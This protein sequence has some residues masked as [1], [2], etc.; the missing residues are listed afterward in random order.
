[1]ESVEQKTKNQFSFCIQNAF[2]DANSRLSLDLGLWTLVSNPAT[3]GFSSLRLGKVCKHPLLSLRCVGS[4]LVSRL[5][6]LI[7]RIVLNLVD[8]LLDVLLVGTRA[9]EQHILGVYH[10]IVAQTV[11]DGYLTLRK[12]Y[13]R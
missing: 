5:N 10:D 3:A 6:M 9:D 4:S 1:M 2:N 12:R 7:S 13:D 8:I 11:D